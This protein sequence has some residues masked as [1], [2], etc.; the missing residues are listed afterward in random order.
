MPAIEQDPYSADIRRQGLSN[1]RA[2]YGSQAGPATQA[3]QTGFDRKI[4]E[5]ALQ[6][7]MNMMN[8]GLEQERINMLMKEL[9]LARQNADW[10]KY[11]AIAKT[12]G[13][14]GIMAATGV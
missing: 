3:F 8:Q 12:L 2:Q 5:G 1:L 10:Q 4:M 11:A 7:K 9:A 6:R 13:Q 14:L